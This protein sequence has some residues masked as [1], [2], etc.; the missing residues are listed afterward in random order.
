MLKCQCFKG[1]FAMSE[2]TSIEPQVKDKRRCSIFIDGRFYCGMKLE[3]AIKNRL[4]VGQSINKE[5][6]D[7]LQLETEKSEAV[8]RAMTHLSSSPKTERE[9][10]T[11]LA[12]KGYVGA[13]VDFVVE[14]LKGY[15]YL[16]DG[17][18]CRSY[19]EGASGK[20]KRA[21][22][23]ELLRRGVDRTTV[24]E[25]LADYSDDEEEIFALLEK[26]LRGKERTREN[27]YRGCRYL[28]SKGYDYDKV[29]S[30]CGRMGDGED[31]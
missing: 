25:E 2:I 22:E 31:Y 12:K 17:A 13:V 10:R 27:I 6:L 16:G 8:D 19:L 23:A 28:I 14:K 29:K 26:Y 4:K 3:V 1:E 21:M 15:G 18:Y 20:S 30:A 24:E 5:E 11:F 9:M 7:R